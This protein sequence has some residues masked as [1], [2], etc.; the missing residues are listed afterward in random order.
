VALH[1]EG[2]FKTQVIQETPSAKP[3]CKSHHLTIFSKNYLAYSKY[4]ENMR[5]YMRVPIYVPTCVLLCAY[6]L[7]FSLVQNEIENFKNFKFS[8]CLGSPDSPVCTGHC[9][10]HCLVHRL[11]ACRFPFCSTL[12]CGSPDNYGALSGV[13]QTGTV[14][15]PM[16]P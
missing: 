7:G 11:C 9:T 14:D 10:V 16:R 5:K 6:K 3:Q 4:F 2:V 8:L 15:Y 13:H 1:L 12:S